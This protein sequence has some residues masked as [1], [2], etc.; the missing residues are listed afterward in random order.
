MVPDKVQAAVKR[1]C[2]CACACACVCVCCAIYR[3]DEVGDSIEILANH[4]HAVTGDELQ[5]D[6]NVENQ[7]ENNE[8][9]NA[10][11]NSKYCQMTTA[12]LLDKA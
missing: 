5:L 9:N 6:D 3:D 8:N 11:N 4:S 7:L 12:L 10:N 2:A 1:F